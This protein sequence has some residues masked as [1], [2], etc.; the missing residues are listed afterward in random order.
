MANPNAW[1]VMAVDP[2]GTTGIATALI[3]IEQPTVASCIK[4]AMRKGHINTWNLTGPYVDQV[5]AIQKASS[6]FWYEVHILKAY[7]QAMRCSLVV[8]GFEIHTL[9]AD[10]I[11]LQILSGLETLDAAGNGAAKH[12]DDFFVVQRPM[13]QQFC[14]DEMLQDWG[15]WKG[16]STHERSAL[17]HLAKRIDGLLKEGE[18]K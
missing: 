15:L 11:P 8:E 16:K 6:E 1:A 3:N 2:G 14:T 18:A 17:K 9:A 4:R 10:V 12:G 5:L 13:D 7:I